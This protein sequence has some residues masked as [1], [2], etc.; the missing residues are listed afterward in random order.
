MIATYGYQDVLFVSGNMFLKALQTGAYAL[1]LPPLAFLVMLVVTRPGRRL[2]LMRGARRL[3]GRGALALAI[4]FLPFLL[5]SLGDGHVDITNP[6]PRA[7]LFFILVVPLL[8]LWF[9]C[10]WCCTVYWAARTGLWTGEIHPLLAPVGTTAL[11]L[12]INGLELF[13]GDTKGVPHGLW[14]TLNLCGTV[15]SLMLAAL[16]YRH[17]R[18]VGYRFR[19]GPEPVTGGE[20]EPA[21]T[22]PAPLR[23]GDVAG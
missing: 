18:S 13:E 23:A 16:E 2:Q 7:A 8:I 10:F 22:G 1:L 9:V 12:L 15:T 11:M 5:L 17:L 21:V 4:F 3:L 14:L 19:S 20:P 6:D